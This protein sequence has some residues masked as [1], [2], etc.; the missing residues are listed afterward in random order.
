MKVVQLK[1]VS[2]AVCLGFSLTATAQ[3]VGLVN[4]MGKNPNTGNP[5]MLCVWPAGTSNIETSSLQP[6][7][8]LGPG[9]VFVGQLKTSGTQGQAAF[10]V[11]LN[12]QDQCTKWKG[13]GY[14]G[15]GIT[16]AGWAFNFS[17]TPLANVTVTPSG[18]SCGAD[19]CYVVTEKEIPPGPLVPNSPSSA[20]PKISDYSGQMVKYRGFNLSGAEFW[21]NQDGTGF[22]PGNIPSINDTTPFVNMGENTVR[23]PFLWEYL[24]PNFT[25]GTAMSAPNFGPTSYGNAILQ[26]VT[27]LT[28][29]GLYV[30]LDMHDYMRYES[31][32]S[33]IMNESD[34]SDT[35]IIDT[36]G[37]PTIVDY[38]NTWGALA[39]AV[40]TYVPR[41]DHV[42]FELM[43]E[44]HDMTKPISTGSTGPTAV[45]DLY[46]AAIASIRVAEGNQ[47]TSY[48]HLILLDGDFYSGLH[49]WGTQTE[50]GD[51]V[52]N[53]VAFAATNI[54][55]QD[56][57]YA[58]DVHQYMDSNFSGTSADCID[59]QA[60]ATDL[61]MTSSTAPGYNGFAKWLAQEHEVAF[62]GEFGAGYD[63]SNSNYQNCEGDF[64][65]LLDQANSVGGIIGWTAWSTGHAWGSSY[66]LNLNPGGAASY[67]LTDKQVFANPAFLTVPVTSGH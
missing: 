34:S 20:W 28:N 43:N 8:N 32:Q 19:V 39:A 59:P 50:S 12:S 66:V 30:I 23:V 62:I 58:I 26:L 49:S 11:S 54:K 67:Y 14:Y 21:P 60:F 41:S 35:D 64:A 5:N 18:N 33:D 37:E 24:Q 52:T 9:A 48:H 63:Q 42:I 1:S 15:V 6:P 53:A 16:S 3:T 17:P 47:P 55:D 56:N 4:Q 61:Q 13:E 29:Q 45:V 57:N 65:Y 22:Y 25:V 36:K 7:A 40:N 38:A 10:T 31:N 51:T 27:D 44:P 2:L 46:N